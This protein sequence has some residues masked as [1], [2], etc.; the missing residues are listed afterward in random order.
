MS[1]LALWN[2][3]C[4]FWACV[5]SFDEWWVGE[6]GGLGNLFCLASFN[7]VE[8]NGRHYAHLHEAEA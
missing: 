2:V 1:E 4:K 6:S 3:C 7:A 8:G 5:E